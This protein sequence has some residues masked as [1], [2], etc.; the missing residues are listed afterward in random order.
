MANIEFDKIP[1]SL[2]K[3]GVY[4]EYNAKGAVTT[5]PNNEQEV[6]IVAPMVGG[7]TAFSQPVRVYSDLDAAQAFGS[8]SWAHL[9]T[10]MAIQNNSLIRLSVME[11]KDS[12]SGVAA[13]GSLTLTGTATSQGVMTATIAGINYKVTVATGEKSDAVA[14]RLNAVIN[15]SEDCPTTATVNEST[16]TLTAKCKG[17]IGNEIDF[18]VTNTTAGLTVTAAAFANGEENA[19]LTAALASVA[20]T[21]YNVIISPF[22]DD[23]NAKALRE[24]LETVSAP[25][26]KK[27]A[28]GVLAWRGSMATGTTYTEKINS[29]RVTCAWYKGA[30]ESGALI[31]AGYGAVIAGEEDPARPLNTLEIKGLTEVDP[32]QTPLLTEANQALYHGLTPVT[33]VNHR[34]RIMRAITTYT[35]SATNTDDPSYL[36]LTTIRTLDYVRKAIEQR[37]ELRFPRAKLSARTPDKVRSEILDVLVRLENEEIIENVA[38][39]KA[40]LLVQRSG[41]DPNRLDCAI[42]TDVV[43]GLHIVANRVDLIL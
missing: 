2:R 10:R 30:I 27:P 26:E 38:Q 37:I 40:K 32:T 18:A 1:N 14:T 11:L 35:K 3:P 8:G 12:A 19:D 15:G 43:N 41:I 16:I 36:D 34:V 42:P 13:S 5:L 17:E 22:A 33:V 21:H 31:A 25:L 7:T 39:H 29:E 28:I 6:L 20:G 23:K 24:H 9:M 4:T